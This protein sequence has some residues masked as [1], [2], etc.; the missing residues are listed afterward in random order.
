MY[1][2]YLRTERT[3]TPVL[4]E[5]GTVYFHERRPIS[6]RLCEWT[7]GFLWFLVGVVLVG[8]VFSF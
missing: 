8:T 2:E 3:V 1:R 4:R 7:L 6:E 5:D